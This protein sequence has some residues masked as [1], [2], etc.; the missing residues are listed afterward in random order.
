M[1]TR[2]C[3]VDVIALCSAQ[4]EL[5]PLRVR[6]QETGREAL[7]IDIDQILSVE[8]VHHVGAEAQIFLCRVTLWEQSRVLRLR[9]GI[10][11]H[12]WSLDI[13]RGS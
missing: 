1:V 11:S 10:R 2:E 12:R 5:R 4:G 13:P 9:Y 6:L 7:R 3:P 8:Q